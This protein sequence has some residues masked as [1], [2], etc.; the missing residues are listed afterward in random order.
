MDKTQHEVF[1]QRTEYSHSQ[2]QE[3]YEW[4]PTR[5]GLAA[6]IRTKF[7]DP[8][9]YSV[10]RS[11]SYIAG[12]AS[13][14]SMSI[15]Y[16]CTLQGCI[17]FCPCHCCID[18]EVSCKKICGNYPCTNCSRQC[19]EHY[20][21]L[22]RAFDPATDQFTVVTDRIDCARYII[23]YT[24]IPISCQNC[25]QDTYE[26][27]IFH[28]V[29]HGRCKFCV[30]EMR[31]IRNLIDDTSLK[32]FKVAVASVRTKDERTC[33]HCLKILD[34]S[35]ERKVHEKTIH[36]KVDGNHKCNVC[37]KNYSNSTNLKYH[38]E[39]HKDSDKISCEFCNKTFVSQ[40]G[41]SIHREIAHY[42]E[43]E[44]ARKYSCEQ[45]D[46]KFTNLSN[47]ARHKRIKH[48]KSNANKE[49]AECF[50][51]VDEFQCDQCESIFKR[52]DYL[53]RHKQAIHDIS[54]NFQCTS[55]E[56]SFNRSDK[57]AEHI[58]SQHSI[59]NK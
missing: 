52:K 45:C 38:L 27:Q 23:P 10:S 32:A 29:F 20:L 22:P 5:S 56:K 57:L 13:T 15:M 17:I 34:A 25:T 50:K 43:P 42:T 11:R 41:L 30:M 40:N 21:R 8:V 59:V 49:F 46:K 33:A 35:Y 6:W 26:H 36:E 12:A 9:S 7:D 31:P 16:T 47:L 58:K 28:H 3:C 48:F 14:S 18:I 51:Y 53:K 39:K 24:G 19:T 4:I 44:N 55:C 37:R 1:K 54:S 2:D